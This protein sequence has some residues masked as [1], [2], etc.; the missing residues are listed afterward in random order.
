HQIEAS[1]AQAADVIAEAAAQA[2]DAAAAER[3]RGAVDIQFGTGAELGTDA[4]ERRHPRRLDV[5]HNRSLRPLRVAPRR[6]RHLAH[7][8]LL[9]CAAI[10]TCEAPAFCAIDR[11]FTA[12][13]NSTWR[14]PSSTTGT[15]GLPL[16]RARSV[17]STWSM[18]VG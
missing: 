18:E 2:A 17:S 5:A 13:P 10:A 16:I 14:S 4:G 1:L 8:D 6:L 3:E 7:S 11:I 12:S 9:R 15:S